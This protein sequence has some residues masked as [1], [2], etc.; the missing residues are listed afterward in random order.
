MPRLCSILPTETKTEEV[1]MRAV[2]AMDH[3]IISQWFLVCCRIGGMARSAAL[4]CQ[5]LG[6]SSGVA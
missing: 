5:L 4:I 6:K 1:L 2:L 3:R